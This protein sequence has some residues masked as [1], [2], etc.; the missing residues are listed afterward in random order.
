MMSQS[1]H[2]YEELI[3]T[4]FLTIWDIGLWHVFYFHHSSIGAKVCADELWWNICGSVMRILL[5]SWLRSVHGLPPKTYDEP[6]IFVIDVV[7]SMMKFQMSC[8]KT[9]WKVLF[10]L[11]YMVLSRFMYLLLILIISPKAASTWSLAR[12]GRITLSCLE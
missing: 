8:G 11:V 7:Y 4:V 6:G 12:F 2:K 3:G 1:H 5:S 9:S 10:L